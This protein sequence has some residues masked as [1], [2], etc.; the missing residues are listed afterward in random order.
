M[1]NGNSLPFGDP[2]HERQAP[3]L[4]PQIQDVARWAPDRRRAALPRAF[5]LLSCPDP[6]PGPG[7]WALHA[8]ARPGGRSPARTRVRH[9][10]RSRLLYFA[11]VLPPRL[12]ELCL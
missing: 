10:T 4:K 8:A 6:G 9:L 11:A 3:A 2:L 1:G 12:F 7:I 5:F